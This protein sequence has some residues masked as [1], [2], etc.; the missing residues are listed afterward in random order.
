MR[1]CHLHS[2]DD[3]HGYGFN[4]Q[5]HPVR[6]GQFVWGVDAGSPAEAAGLVDGDRIIEVNG[7]NVERA[8]H[9]E[10][11]EKIKS[12]SGEVKLLVV[13]PDADEFFTN[14]KIVI[15]ESMDCVDKITCPETKPAALIG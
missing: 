2:W 15:V 6:P 12:I 7:D 13:D 4:M 5:A 8:T 3:G 14:N 9:S 10:V 11:V 1:L